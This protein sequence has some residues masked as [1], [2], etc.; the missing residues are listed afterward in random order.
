MG[1]RGRLAHSKKSM[2]LT[3]QSRGYAT[4]R[5][6]K[7]SPETRSYLRNHTRCVHQGH[8]SLGKGAT[9]RGHG[10]VNKFISNVF[11]MPGWPEG[12]SFPRQY[13]VL[14][15]MLSLPCH[16]H[17][18]KLLL[19]IHVEPPVAEGKCVPHFVPVPSLPQLRI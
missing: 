8:A 12:D 2:F 6:T 3:F 17:L 9:W 7:V 1:G 10:G 15:N 16:T 5:H 14:Q 4:C 19:F 11:S 13:P 18:I